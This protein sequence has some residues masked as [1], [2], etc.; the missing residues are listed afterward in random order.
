MKKLL[1][2]LLLPIQ[3]YAQQATY[4][5]KGESPAKNNKKWVY[6]AKPG[7]QNT[8]PDSVMIVDGHFTFKGTVAEPVQVKLFLKDPAAKLK[9]GTSYRSATIFLENSPME[10]KLTDS[11]QNISVKGSKAEE[12]FKMFRKLIKPESDA[13]MVYLNKFWDMG[14]LDKMDTVRINFDDRMD[15]VKGVFYQKYL[16]YMLANPGSPICMYL[17]KDYETY[18]AQPELMKAAFAAFPAS[19]KAWPSAKAFAKR[20]DIALKLAP[21]QMAKDFKVKDREGKWVNFS[22]IADFKGKYVLIDF[23]ASWCGPCREEMPNVLA[24]YKKYKGA[25]LA[26]MAISMDEPQNTNKWLAAIKED[27]T[28]DMYQ[29]IDEDRIAGDLYDIQSIPQNYLIDPSGKIVAKNIKGVHLRRKMT[30]LFH[31]R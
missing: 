7:A 12:D 24:T 22:D 6:L 28:E 19:T 8:A 30:A 4:T 27:G 13:Y 10:L 5:I 16:D 21:G 1:I 29:T 15:L 2:A 18:N 14:S 11:I 26:V 9:N 17:L 23:W 3:L 31:G 25:G 20:L